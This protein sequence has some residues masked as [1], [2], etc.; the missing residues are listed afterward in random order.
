MQS[1]PKKAVLLSWYLLFLLPGTATAVA[2]WLILRRFLPVAAFPVILL[3]LG[4][5]LLFC[6]WYLPRRR[7][8]MRYT[9]TA[10]ELTVTGGVLFAVRHRMPLTAVRHV[11]LLQGPVERL[12]GIAYLSVSGLGGHILLEGLERKQAEVWCRRLLLHG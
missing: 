3:W 8:H 9:L 1:T 5:L 4:G 12:C 11:T 7:R 2:V 6:L 10:G